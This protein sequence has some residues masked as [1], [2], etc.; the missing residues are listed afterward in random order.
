MNIELKGFQD[1]TVQQLLAKCRRA[2]EEAGNGDPQAV[3]LSAP[4][5]SGKTVMVTAL[6]EALAEGDEAGEGD[7]EAT[8]LWITDQPELNEQTRRK[9]LEH[10]SAFGPDRLITIDAAF[11]REVFVPGRIHFLNIQKLREGSLLVKQGDLRSYTLWDTITNTAQARPKSFWVILDEAHKGMAQSASEREKA[12][13]IVQKFIKGSAEIPPIQLILGMS[14]TPQRFVDLV[15]TTRTLR[16]EDVPVDEVRASGLLKETILL[17][18]PDESQPADITLLKEAAKQLLEFEQRWTSYYDKVGTGEVVRPILV[19]Q[20][21]DASASRPTTRTDLPQAIEAVEEVLGPLEEAEVGHAFQEGAAI[22]I[23][24]RKIRYCAPPDIQGDPDLRVVLFKMSLN[25]GWDCPRAEVMMSFRKAVDHTFIAQLVGRM[26]RTPLARRIDTDEFLNTVS[27]YL[28]HYDRAGL[29]RILDHLSEPD[30]TFMPPV[31]VERGEKAITLQRNPDLGDCFEALEEIPTY[32]VS[33]VRKASNVRRLMKLARLLANDG[34]VPDAVERA[35]EL[36]IAGLD[37]AR[38]KL[39][40]KQQFKKVV[41]DSGVIDLR[42][43]AYAYG[44]GNTGESATQI[45]VTQENVDDLFEA[46]G[47]KLGEGL[48]KTYWRARVGADPSAKRRRAKLELFALVHDDSTLKRLENNAARQI[49]AWQEQYWPSI[50]RLPPDRIDGYHQVRQ[51]AVE[52]EPGYMV[53]PSAIQGR[54]AETPCK[55]HLYVGEDGMFRYDFSQSSWERQVLEAEQARE[56]HVGFLRNEPRKTWS[57]CVPY[58]RRGET[59]PQYPDFVFFRRQG[60][61]IVVDI[62]DPHNPS[63]EDWPEK[64]V[65]LA[66]YAAQ[67][68]HLFGRIELIFVDRTGALKRLD[69][70]DER[71]RNRVREVR[72]SA[73]L[74]QLFEEG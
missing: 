68:G 52:P 51:T 67:H 57:L 56:D 23:D 42:A 50:R 43:V 71:M 3:I 58:R 13:T 28:P 37:A 7:R 63:L 24:S 16:T 48:H 27:L 32:T 5:G 9:I 31:T 65:G 73:H 72:T 15:G 45:P 18:H 39:Q 14:A 4:T 40:G 59:R 33:S 30:P 38:T 17:F 29:Q 6:M 36:V 10:S 64:A 34:I 69:L 20:V 66:D 47:R 26:V 19:L 11:D 21:E 12:Q 2:S 74:N 62:L 41:K 61:E 8:F 1:A 49:K 70:T 55:G 53:M 46:A 25:T 54:K 35:R 44:G 22:E 60:D